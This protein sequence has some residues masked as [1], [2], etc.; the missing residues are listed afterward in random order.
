[1]KTIQQTKNQTVQITQSKIKFSLKDKLE[2]T[3]LAA[4]CLACGS[5][6]FAAIIQV[7]LK[8]LYFILSVE[9]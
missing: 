4:A 1:M 8:V 2:M 7:S 5:A 6:L 9:I 3:F